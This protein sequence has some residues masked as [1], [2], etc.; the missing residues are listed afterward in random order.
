M[1]QWKDIEGYEGQYQVSDMGRVRSLPARSA[2]KRFSGAVL[3]LM[4]G[5]HGYSLVNLSRK[6]FYV[7]RLVAMA[8]IENP[9]GYKCV[10]HK[11]EDKT[12][13]CVDNLEWC[14]HKYNNNYGTRN[15]RISENGGRKILQY[16]LDRRLLK[17]WCSAAKAAK[18]YGV[19]RTTICGCCAGRQ[20]TSCGFIWRYADEPL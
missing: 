13:N 3:V 10:N 18:H 7:H 20:H 5:K 11:D 9:N 8:F 2:T 19:R 16:S 15:K 6:T 4:T 12:N 17:E 14:T 1:E